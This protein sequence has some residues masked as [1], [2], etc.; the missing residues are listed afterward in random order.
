MKL[1]L[2]QKLIAIIPFI[3]ILLTSCMTD[4]VEEIPPETMY[5]EGLLLRTEGKYADASKKFE[6]IERVHPYSPYA[7]KALIN[8]AYTNYARK[9]YTE[10]VSSAERFTTLYPGSEDSAY[11][12]YI[13]GNSY[14]N[15][16]PDVTRDQT[17]TQKAY[18]AFNELIQR[19][20]ESEYFS[21]AEEKLIIAQ[22]QLAGKE[23]LTGRYYLQKRNFI[24]AI[25]RFRRVI[26]DYQTTRHIEEALART[27][28]SYYALGV[29]SESQT[30][31]AVLGHNFPESEWYR[32]TYA[33]LQRGG[34]EPSENTGSWI[35][36][37]F[38]RKGPEAELEIEDDLEGEFDNESGQDLDGDGQ[39]DTNIEE[40]GV[41]ESGEGLVPGVVADPDTD[42][43]RI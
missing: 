23:M 26:L 6:D 12:L 25:N 7:K 31:A 40:E 38:E 32:D 9:R 29:V 14:L 3:A 43:E 19:Y 41:T 37:A 22:D 35:S 30:A 28:E 13:V 20:P 27:S 4:E 5:N 21:D 8:L 17:V 42:S 1:K 15:Q 11:A 39:P 33:L 16:M 36:R 24:G 10:A 18:D 34:F 2:F